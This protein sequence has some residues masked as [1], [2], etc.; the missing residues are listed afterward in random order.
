MEVMMHTG[1]AALPQELV[2][3]FA[4]F[5][6]FATLKK[7][8]LVCRPWLQS[9]RRQLF[10]SMRVHTYHD[11]RATNAPG[12]R[13]LMSFA[14]M[15][16]DM[17]HI[18]PY[19]QYVQISGDVDFT[20]LISVLQKLNQLRALVLGGITVHNIPPVVPSPPQLPWSIP[21]LT[22][23]YV[24]VHDSP[25]TW[26]FKLYIA[27]MYSSIS[28]LCI[29]D[30]CISDTLNTGRFQQDL[31][32]SVVH[33]VEP[34]LLPRIVSIFPMNTNY[35]NK[36]WP[37]EIFLEALM[38][39]LDI[40]GTLTIPAW[41]LLSCVEIP[42]IAH[43]ADVWR[44]LRTIAHDPIQS[45][46]YPNP[47]GDVRTIRLVFNAE[48]HSHTLRYAATALCADSAPQVSSVVLVFHGLSWIEGS[49]AAWSHFVATLGGM[50]G[51]QELKLEVPDWARE[52][53]LKESYPVLMRPL[54]N[55]AKRLGVVVEPKGRRSFKL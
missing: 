37:V 51:L 19:L 35:K 34:I 25:F 4:D 29:A 32:M 3:H 13:D 50:N 40:D 27:S 30:E 43:F 39:L 6:D 48:L 5:M 9:A 2:D 12:G 47:L 22:L 18:A 17:P 11:L 41:P 7:S 36:T 1:M 8:S 23:S 24:R 21:S 46:S 15:I 42:V 33:V 52:Q 44:R 14:G 28:D 16:K 20:T 55:L 10:R 26:P 31:H 49:Q 45:T 53:W 38:Q 54:G